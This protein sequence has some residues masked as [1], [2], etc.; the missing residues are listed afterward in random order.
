MAATGDPVFAKIKRDF[1]DCVSR[2]IILGNHITKEKFPNDIKNKTPGGVSILAISLLAAELDPPT[3][4]CMKNPKL[5]IVAKLANTHA[6]QVLWAVHNFAQP[7]VLM[8]TR[9]PEYHIMFKD[10][11]KQLSS[12]SEYNTQAM[13]T[14]I[15]NVTDECTL[16]K[17]KYSLE[18][19]MIP[20]TT[21]HKNCC[22]ECFTKSK[23]NECPFCHV[24][25]AVIRL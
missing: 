25:R 14:I 23:K 6:S 12:A 22:H 1:P 19:K 10:E 9:Y 7:Q 17:R 16:C 4:E 24:S 8:I 21:C 3:R 2:F 15:A 13:R 20:C 11:Y 18:R 5:I